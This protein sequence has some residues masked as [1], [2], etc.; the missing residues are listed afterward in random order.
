MAIDLGK[1]Y[2]W[3]LFLMLL[4]VNV[5]QS[6]SIKPPTF[7]RPIGSI[8]EPK[9]DRFISFVPHT[10]LVPEEVVAGVLEEY[11]RDSRKSTDRKKSVFAAGNLLHLL[12]NLK[13]QRGRQLKVASK[14]VR[15][16]ISRK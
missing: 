10:V 4:L 13:S 5:P 14:S 8:S 6:Q 7:Q 12:Q 11:L 1:Q 3:R 2:L 9:E 15:F 16:G